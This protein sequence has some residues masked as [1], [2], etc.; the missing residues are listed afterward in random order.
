MQWL[1]TDATTVG[2]AQMPLQIAPDDPRVSEFLVR[3][4]EEIPAQ[5]PSDWQM[6]LYTEG[7]HQVLVRAGKSA[8]F[9]QPSFADEQIITKIRNAYPDL[10]DEGTASF[11]SAVRSRVESDD[12]IR[13]DYDQRFR[14]ALVNNAAARAELP[15]Y[16][17]EF[18]PMDD[19]V[20]EFI[21]TMSTAH[22][23]FWQGYL[24]I[25]AL[26]REVA[27]LTKSRPFQEGSP[28]HQALFGY[29]NEIFPGLLEDL[30]RHAVTGSSSFIHAIQHRIEGEHLI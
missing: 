13:N 27:R 1:R 23:K 21:K 11:L 18:D 20:T 16:T 9:D 10:D 19:R 15:I 26:E 17:P 4:R 24:H 3:I 2:D 29:A 5:W 7:L 8:K 30:E 12:L 6:F 22:S 14:I 28:F 25:C